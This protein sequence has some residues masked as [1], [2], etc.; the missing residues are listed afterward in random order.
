MATNANY[1][2]LPLY[3]RNSVVTYTSNEQQANYWL[4]SIFLGKI[5]LD[6]EFTKR[7]PDDEEEEAAKVDGSRAARLLFIQQRFQQGYTTDWDAI[8]ICTVQI[9]HRDCMLVMDIKRMKGKHFLPDHIP[10]RTKTSLFTAFPNQLK[11]ILG[12]RS[13]KK[14]LVNVLTDGKTFFE[15]FGIDMRNMVEL[16]LLV[17]FTHPERYR[18]DGFKSVE[19]ALDTYVADVL[20]LYL[21][22]KLRSTKWNKAAPLTAEEIEYAAMDAQAT[23]EVYEAIVDV[24]RAKEMELGRLISDDWYTMDF[25][26]GVPTRIVRA[27]NKETLN[28]SGKL[29]PWYL[30]GDFQNYFT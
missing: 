4:S 20:G 13:I 26:Q 11:R 10:S 6:T 22:K 27:Y 23:L 3:A 21:D 16:G 24:T 25:I 28:W 19:L 18:E 9:A 7:V 2:K 14:A 12:S 8:A 17:K 5:G 29:C 1:N 15:D 30:G